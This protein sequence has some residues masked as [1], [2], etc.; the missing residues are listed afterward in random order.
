MEWSVEADTDALSAFAFG[1]ATS[2]IRRRDVERWQ[3]SGALAKRP[4]YEDW[5]RAT[6]ITDE[7]SRRKAV[8]DWWDAKREAE[9][10][11]KKEQDRKEH[12]EIR[13]RFDE[14]QD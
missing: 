6:A 2:A 3:M 5:Q 9:L 13:V 7:T 10:A 14:R 1:S 8:D 12:E 11:E 4:T